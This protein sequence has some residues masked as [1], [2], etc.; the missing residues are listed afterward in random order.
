MIRLLIYALLVII[1]LIAGPQLVAYK[2]YVMISIADYT[3]ETSVVALAI[4]GLV[5]FGALQVAEWLL[6][7]TINVTGATLLL[8][9]RWGQKRAK[10]HTMNG[11]LALA[12]QDWVKAEK[13]MAKGAKAGEVPMI[14]FLA[15]A[16]AAHHRGDRD[17]WQSYLTQAEQQAE[18]ATTAQITRARYLMDDGELS[19]ARAQYDALDSSTQ[20]KPAVRRLALALFRKQQ[21]WDALAQLIPSVSKDKS[22]PADVLVQLP[23]EVEQARFALCDTLDGLTNRW[24]ALPRNQKKLAELQAA[25]GKGL[26][27]LGATEKARSLML[28]KLSKS[29]PQPQLLAVLL[30]AATG[31]EEEI[32]NILGRKYKD[33][34]DPAL[35]DCYGALAE[36]RKSLDT[37]LV[38]RQQALDGEATVARLQSLINLQE[39]LGKQEAALGNYRRMLALMQS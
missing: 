30:L 17:A 16:R 31:A 27:R 13:A 4:I 10:Q 22:L 24:D 20:A 36:Q 19:Q 28:D 11:F 14:N 23:I 39:Q 2:G 35:L 9:K 15:A 34:Q 12:E 8:P 6:I 29:Q 5:L 33:S 7:K 18:A 26:I 21:D 32:A 38:H 25:Y 1:G 3:V 37:A